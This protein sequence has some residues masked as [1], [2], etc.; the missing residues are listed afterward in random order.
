MGAIIFSIDAE[1]AWGFHDQSSLPTNRLV[2]ARSAWRSVIE[3]LE[4]Y[5]LP[6]TWAIVGHLMLQRCDGIHDTHPAPPGWFDRD[7]GGSS[8]AESLWF[9]PDLVRAILDSNLDHEV[10][11][12]TFSH[13][14]LGMSEVTSEMVDAELLQHR[15]IAEQWGIEL[16]SLVFPR[17]QVAYR[18]RIAAHHYSSYRGTSPPQWYDHSTF[19]RLGKTVDLLAGRWVPVVTPTID[20]FGLLDIPASL[21]LFGFEGLAKRLVTP[22]VGDPIVNAAKRGIDAAA[23]GDGIFHGWLHPNNIT[24]HTDIRRLETVFQLASASSAPVRT[25]RQISNEGLPLTPA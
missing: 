23:R 4:T 2:N 8:D 22:V 9:S 11:S 20:E 12:H 10:A 13:L 19:R 25:M 7:P 21:D 15:D 16:D 5:E 24:D 14:P 1:L 3:L 6:A 18:D 17:N